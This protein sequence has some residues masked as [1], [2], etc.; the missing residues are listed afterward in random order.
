MARADNT[1][2]AAFYRQ[3]GSAPGEPGLASLVCLPE[4]PSDK[5]P[6]D[7]G[8]G[9]KK[10]RA[11]HKAGSV[12]SVEAPPWWN[13]QREECVFPHTYI[14]FKCGQHSVQVHHLLLIT[15]VSS[16]T[17]IGRKQSPTLSQELDY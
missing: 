12:Y 4:S 14:H 3:P 5:L 1:R 10:G 17:S 13:K 9:L 7:L 6:L 15:A 11:G 16:C 2:M 8:Q